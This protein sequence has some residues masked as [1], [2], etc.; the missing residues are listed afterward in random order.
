MWSAYYVLNTFLRILH[1]LS[2][3]ISTAICKYFYD[4]NFQRSKV[5]YHLA[6]NH[7]VS[8]ESTI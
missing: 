7:T 3:S 2:H 1:V 4:A 8:G 6:S 5:K